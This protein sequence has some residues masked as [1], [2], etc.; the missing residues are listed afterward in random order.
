MVEVDFMKPPRRKF[1][2]P[3]ACAIASCV[4]AAIA[5]VPI[6]RGAWSQAPRTIKIVVPVPPGG[7]MDF[8]ARLL[9]DQIGHTQ[10]VTVL[11]ESRPGA[12]AMIATE[13]V[14]RA[15]PDGATLLI[16][17]PSFVIDPH[18]RKLSYDPLT[19][20]EPVCALVA[21]PNVI[22]VNGA[23]PFRTLADLVDA[24]RSHPGDL[25]IASIGPASQQ[26]MAIEMLK[27]AAGIELTYIPYSGS[28]PTVTALLGEHVT[29]LMAAYANLAEQLQSGRLRALAAVSRTRI[30]QLPNVPTI[31]ESGYRDF[32]VDNWFGVLAPA[33]TSKETVSRL[34]GWFAAAMQVPEVKAKLVAQGLYPVAICG[35]DFGKLLRK[36]YDEY[37]RLV[38]E[39]S[40]KAQ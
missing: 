33:K 5:T 39:T 38:R 14:S 3:M 35:A 12:G 37:G 4:I 27:R 32:E 30:E 24:A 8:L 26:Q 19:S 23:S 34:S 21:A 18:V 11:I 10:G 22:A 20:F 6:G 40:I 1:L 16:Q 36:Q 31:A 9:A 13:A 29:S 15:A 17:S 25:T 28:A 2:R 7:G